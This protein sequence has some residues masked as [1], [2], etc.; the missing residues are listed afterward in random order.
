MA[1][2]YS[3]DG[4]S[5]IMFYLDKLYLDKY[6]LCVGLWGGTRFQTPERVPGILQLYIEYE[7]AS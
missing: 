2:E 5:R 3:M 1:A 4:Q 7:R 6:I